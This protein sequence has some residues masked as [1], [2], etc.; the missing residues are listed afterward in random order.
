MIQSIIGPRLVEALGYTLLHSLWLGAAFA[1]ALAVG[2]LLMRRAEARVRYVVCV[3]AMAGFALSVGGTLAYEYSVSTATMAVASEVQGPGVQMLW[4]ASTQAAPPLVLAKAYFERHLPLLVTLWLLGMLACQLRL[5]G[6][7]AY[8]QRLK[9]RGVSALPT[10]WRLRLPE[11]EAKLN[12]RRH[13]SYLASSQATT[14][15][16]LGWLKPVVL[17]PKILL[18]QLSET[19]FYAIVAHEL[20]HVK[21]E[22]YL[23]NVCQSILKAAF[24]FHPGVWWMS[25][26]TDEEREHSCDDLAVAATG[27]AMPYARTLL[28]LST[29][30]SAA[31]TPMLAMAASGSN[32]GLATRIRRLFDRKDPEQGNGAGAV[33]AGVLAL[34]LLVVLG[35]STGATGASEADTAFAKTIATTDTLPPAEVKQVEEQYLDLQRELNEQIID[36]GKMGREINR[37]QMDSGVVPEEEQAAYDELARGLAPQ[38]R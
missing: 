23:I 18:D 32:S 28:H 22:D 8:V 2:L 30:T 6:R 13:V 26:R 37:G 24:F 27:D 17:F 16:V 34:S 1:V 9:H 4:T 3:S 5:L 10:R 15:M 38:A 12:L 33:S 11:L 20:A 21:R 35:V 25:E 7:L 19:E 31:N 14:P 29:L 36:L